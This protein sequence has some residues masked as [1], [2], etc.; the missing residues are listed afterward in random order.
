MIR[1]IFSDKSIQPLLKAQ[2]DNYK[3]QIP[4]FFKEAL[5]KESPSQLFQD[6]ATTGNEFF[7]HEAGNA[8]NTL[9]SFAE[10]AKVAATK[11]FD[12]SK[13]AQVPSMTLKGL[14]EVGQ[15]ADYIFG[16]PGKAAAL[17]LGNKNT[18]YGFS[19]QVGQAVR[20]TTGSPL[21]GTAAGFAAGFAEPVPGKAEIK[22]IKEAKPIFQG[23]QDISTTLLEKLK[24][25]DTVS[26]QFISD[27]TNA[28]DLRQPEK[29][30]IRGLLQHEP[31]TISVPTFADKVK[32]E[33]LPLTRDYPISGDSSATKYESITLPDELRGPIADYREHIYESPIKTSAGYVHFDD[34]AQNYFAHTRIED[35]PNERPI[36]GDKFGR[37]EVSDFGGKTRRVIELQS[38]LFQKGRLEDEIQSAEFASEGAKRI[39]NPALKIPGESEA[40]LKK[41]ED[42]KSKL[43]PYRNTWHER[44]IR[45]EVKQAAKDGKTKLQ[46]PTGETAMKIEGLGEQGHWLNTATD[47][48]VEPNELK[49]GMEVQ[50]ARDGLGQGGDWIIIDV[51]GDGK[52]KAAPKKAFD[53]AVKDAENDGKSREWLL[54]NPDWHRD[55]GRWA[56]EFD[57]SGNADTENPI[58]KF[59]QKT[60]GKYL[61][62]KFNAKEVTDPQGVRWWEIP[63]NKEK[64]KEPIIAYG[65]ANSNTI[66]T[67]AAALGGTAAAATVPSILNKNTTTYDRKEFVSKA[68]Q[69]IPDQFKEPIFQASSKNVPPAMFS[70]VLNAENKRYDSHAVRKNTD[71]S[72][73]YGLFQINS[74]NFPFVRQELKNRGVIFD[75]FNPYHSALAA[76]VLLEDNYKKFSKSVGR[77]PTDDELIGSFNQGLTD[78]IKAAKDD[79]KE[80]K[81]QKAYVSRTLTH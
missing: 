60:V 13:L 27:L 7:K 40:F 33:L 30:L 47:L 52:F 64:A 39:T 21:L 61:Q 69:N 77:P 29:D 75:P 22:A 71:G 1:S 31:D 76:D 8:L 81:Q 11:A 79:I 36:K 51:L 46:F 62:N 26:K 44:I 59:Y 14:D 15:A 37:T 48:R 24:G 54:A 73:D 49:V 20:Q 2:E 25:R 58:Y 50:Q 56:E 28:P 4:D 41:A 70:R 32:T 72:T 63:I 38:D 5:P 16:T 9:K 12:Q 67:G 23:F 53:A 19:E 80:K 68:T 65:K 66:F 6:Y 18:P 74:S 43:Q 3:S 57:I 42:M 17:A 45:E 34:K 55:T 78:T 10:N 35:L